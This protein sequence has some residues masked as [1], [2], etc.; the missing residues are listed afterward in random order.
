MMKT[1]ITYKTST[2]VITNLKSSEEEKGANLVITEGGETENKSII[3]VRRGKNKSIIAVFWS[4]FS[5][6]A[7]L[8]IHLSEDENILFVGGGSLS[9][10]VD[11][12]KLKTLD[13]NYPDLFWGWVIVTDDIPGWF[14]VNLQCYSGIRKALQLPPLQ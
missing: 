11:T 7:N 3:E 4:H 12:S 2:L 8:C 13:I 10:V 6:D 1:E 5:D 14:P 9:A